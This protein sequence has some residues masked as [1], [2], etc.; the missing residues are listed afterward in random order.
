[1]I[2]R[3]V[4]PN[5]LIGVLVMATFVY[6]SFMG[7]SFFES[8]EKIIYEI[9]MRLDM[10]RNPPE[11]KVA[12]VNIDDKSINKLGKWPWPR[13]IIAEMIKILKANGAKLIGLDM[14]F[15]EK[16][17]NPGIREIKELYDK[18]QSREKVFASKEDDKWINK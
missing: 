7:F 9:E 5:I 16:E 17:Q 1:M 6:L 15:S 8:L 2:E 14:V 11:S 4:K 10:P 3:K 18:I 13:H 12:L